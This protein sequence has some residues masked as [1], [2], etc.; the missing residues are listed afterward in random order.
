M[1]SIENL[2]E[3]IDNEKTKEYF[4][5]ILISYQTESYRSAI[6]MLY[7]VVIC[8]IIFKLN[9]MKALYNNQKAIDILNEIDKVQEDNATNPIWEKKL[10]DHV[11][12][13][14]LID[15]ATETNINHLRELRH[16][17]A[18][19]VIN[20]NKGELYSPTREEVISYMKNM[21]KDLLIKPPIFINKIFDDLLEDLSLN[22]SYLINDKQLEKYLDNKYLKHFDNDDILI[23]KTFKSLWKIT[24][25]LDNKDCNQNRDINFR[26]LNILYNKYKNK[27]NL[28]LE[29]EHFQ[30]FLP[31][32]LQSERF[33][34]L[35]NFISRH[36]LYKHFND[37]TQ[38]F[39]KV[40]I[41]NDKEGNYQFL[42]YFLRNDLNDQL[43]FINNNIK[44]WNF[45]HISKDFSKILFEVYEK[46][47]LTQDYLN[48]II[49][50]FRESVSFDTAN[51]NFNHFIMPFFS[52]F[53]ETQFQKIIAAF[54]DNNQIISRWRGKTDLEMVLNEMYKHNFKTDIIHEY[55][56]VKKLLEE[57]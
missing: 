53:D 40:N 14:N 11:A 49:E 27:I 36:N 35:I 50:I 25:Y 22:K 39:L 45:N 2:Y 18:H 52:Y 33:N 5:E 19:P 6:V 7:S 23:T 17:S 29:D 13:T 4:K 51:S 1:D 28:I 21:L 46:E 55:T 47:G 44:N 3:N 16:L 32:E 20:E 38:I 30:K 10:V 54:N 56:H 41:D 12:K 37:S 9:Y 24:F 42:S 26:T 8:D 31:S 57:R 43:N 15:K 48:Q 34:L